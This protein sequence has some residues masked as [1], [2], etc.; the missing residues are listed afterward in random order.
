M[1]LIFVGLFLIVGR[2]H[3]LTQVIG[4]LVLENGIFVFRVITVVGTPLLVE[5]GVLLDAFVGV[6]VM[7]IAIS[8]STANSGRWTSIGSTRCEA[9]PLF[10]GQSIVAMLALAVS[11]ALLSLVLP[12]AGV[13]C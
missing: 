10:A 9:S 4:Y 8:T 1:F 12:R 7:G 3:A 6:F 13:T 5:L 2:R 11:G